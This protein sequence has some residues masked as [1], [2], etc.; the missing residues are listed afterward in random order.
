MSKYNLAQ[1]NVAKVLAPMDDP[2]MNGFVDNLDSIYHISDVHEGFVCRINNEDYPTELRDVFPDES[3]INN[4]SVWKDLNTLFDFT[5]KSGHV[6]ILKKKKEWFS[7]I[8]MQ[9]MGC[10]YVPE[11]Y[12]PIHQEGKQRLNYFNKHGCRPYAFSFKDKFSIAD[13]LNYKPLL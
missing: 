3:F 7:K 9:Y 5:Y 4:I 11:G 12:V 10:W 6:E 2:V 8:Q 13:S 1:V